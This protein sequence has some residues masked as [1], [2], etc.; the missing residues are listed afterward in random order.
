M[1]KADIDIFEFRRRYDYDPNGPFKEGGQ[2]FIYKAWDKEE[3]RFVAIKRAQRPEGN[4]EKYSVLREFQRAMEIPLHP[5]LA[6]YY[7]VHRLKTEMGYFDYGVMEFIEDGTN[8]DDFMRTFP[9]EEKIREM[10]IGILKGMQHLHKHSIIHRDLKPTNILVKYDGGRAIPKIIDF[11]ISKDLGG[12]ET[13][14]SAVVGTFEYMAPEQINPE[15]GQPLHPNADIW[16]FGVIAYRMLRSDMPFGSVEEGDPKTYIQNKI[17]E[18]RLPEDIGEVAEPYQHIIRRCLIRDTRKRFQSADEILDILEGR[19]SHKEAPAGAAPAG[20]ERSGGMTVASPAATRPERVG[21]RRRE[22]LIIT[23]LAFLLAILLGVVGYTIAYPGFGARGGALE[24]YL[25]SDYTRSFA[26]LSEQ[27]DAGGLDAYGKYLMGELY[28][29]GL[30]DGSFIP[31]HEKAAALLE[32]AAGQ[33]GE[34]ALRLGDMHRAGGR[35]PQAKASYE[36]ARGLLEKEEDRATALAALADLYASGERL[37]KVGAKAYY[38][39]ERAGGKGFTYGLWRAGMLLESDWGPK[40]NKREAFRRYQE[41]A[42][43]GDPWGLY[44]LARAYEEGVGV[45]RDEKKARTYYA[46]AADKYLPAALYKMGLC[47][48]EGQLG[49]TPDG[50]KAKNLLEDASRRG[51]P[52]A[53][54][55]LGLICEQGALDGRPDIAEAA[56]LMKA[57]A[58]G[59]DSLAQYKLYEYYY[60]GRAGLEK[61][62]RLGINYLKDA[63]EKGYPKAAYQLGYLYRNGVTGVLPKDAASTF[64]YYK[65]AAE[66]GHLNAWNGLGVLYDNGEGIG[67]DDFKAVN[68]YKKA[69]Y[70]GH[71]YGQLNL[72]KMFEN[73]AGITENRDSCLY[74]YRQ[75]ADKG[76]SE[77]RRELRRLGISADR[78]GH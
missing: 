18:A 61:D 58:R 52:Q 10:L 31:Q 45:A 30:H 21:R 14:A 8:L 50:V 57:A 49:A 69:A 74:W 1:S 26:L 12:Q 33:Y 54:Y 67:E 39:Y 55:Y 40:R 43:L 11:G 75:S 71:P 56:K 28:Y 4:R 53:Q 42:D 38:N 25:A 7:D 22:R 19:A 60:E 62:E 20:E 35:F 5:N 48:L 37:G 66:A 59:G 63:A 73:G 77:A 41:A 78:G 3:E 65:Q 34:A 6:L 68:W 32:E 9:A 17:L 36:K 76:V 15:K 2:G 24:Y 16:A 46:K 64:R 27:A 29:Q 13:Y 23:F 47:Y 51:V 70:A 72:A 44:H